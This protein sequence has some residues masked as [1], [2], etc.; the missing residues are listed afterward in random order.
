MEQKAEEVSKKGPITQ[1]SAIVFNPIETE[2][3]FDSMIQENLSN[4]EDEKISLNLY[5]SIK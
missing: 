1:L 4:D 3:D 2:R 5:R